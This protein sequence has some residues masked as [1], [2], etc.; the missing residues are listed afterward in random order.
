[1]MHREVR[2]ESGYLLIVEDE[3]T[4]QTYNTSILRRHGY[5]V[6]QAFTL[7]EAREAVAL[8]P[9]RAIILDLLLPDGHG[10]DFLR[11]IRQTSNAPVLILTAMGTPQ[12]VIRGLQAGGDD[13]LAK[14]YDI[15]VFLMRVEAL[16]RRSAILPDTLEIGNLRL[17]PASAKAYLNGADMLLSQKEYALLQLFVQYPDKTMS[18]EYLYEK[19]WGLVSI[20][21]DSSLKNTV[22]RLRKK[23]QGSGYNISAER[24]EGYIFERE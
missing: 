3:P 4:V 16:I 19:V 24:G 1:M 15:S 17:E 7:K 12:D 2:M 23:L 13:Y 6:K 10:L 18:V 21:E 14:P 22:Y 11:E 9:P 5:T 20:G 8:S